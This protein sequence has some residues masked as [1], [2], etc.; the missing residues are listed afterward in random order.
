MGNESFDF[1]PAAEGDSGPQP[2]PSWG[3][4]D[5]PLAGGASEDDLTQALDP[6]AIKTAI[7]AASAKSAPALDEKAL[8]E[9]ASDTIRAVMLIR[10]YRVR[11]HLAAT[12]DPLGLS[13][14]ELPADLGDTQ[15][16]AEDHRQWQVLGQ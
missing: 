16:H 4:S 3:R 2:G 10:V 5:W 1:L 11:G 6:L 9:A 8:E 13:K 12:L 15:R 14:R 7:K